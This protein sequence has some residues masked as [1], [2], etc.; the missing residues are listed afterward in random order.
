[1]AFP[2]RIYVIGMPASGKT[3]FG[4][5]LAHELGFQFVDTDAKI[6][7]QEKLSIPEIFAQKGE[8][9]F[10]QLEKNILQ[11]TFRYRN[12]V[13][14]TGGGL[15]CFFDNIQKIKENGF[16]IF[17][18]TPKNILLKR[19]IEQAGQ[20]PIFGTNDP[21]Q[22]AV[23]LDKK[24]KERQKYYEEADWILAEK[25]QDVKKVISILEVMEF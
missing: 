12:V 10:R 1:M 4:T 22:L 16:S 17:L 9:Y 24:L 14:A 23:E 2:N 8:N 25:D 6:S 11:E 19:L 13:I 7:S 20:R 15:P 18:Q 21:E 3:T 5:A